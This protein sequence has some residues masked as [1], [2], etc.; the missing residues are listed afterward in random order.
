[1]RQFLTMRFWMTLVA[2]LALTALVYVATRSDPRSDS[3]IAAQSTPAERHIDFVAPVYAFNGDAGFAMQHGRSSG[4]LQ[5]VIDST[6]T[7]VI[8]PD[9]PG[10]IS[11]T[12]LAEIG[13]CV[14]AADLLGDAVLW[15]AVIPAEPRPSVTLPGIAQLR[16]GNVV[17]L[18]N[19]WVLN[20]AATVDLNC[21]DDVGSLTDFVRRF[22]TTST[23][24]FSFDSQQ[25]V[26]T[27]CTQSPETTTTSVP[28]TPPPVPVG[29]V[30]P[31]DTSVVD[32]GPNASDS[33]VG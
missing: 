17:E 11:C 8:Q 1:V 25:I 27:T 6:R 4:H 21:T 5:L 3:V 15:F 24:T 20:R 18:T 31:I 12:K 28:A 10:E 14:V 30:G 13:Q 26:R 7:M 23:T 22:A 33:G 9:T 2:L 29:T 32:T 19:G 16:D